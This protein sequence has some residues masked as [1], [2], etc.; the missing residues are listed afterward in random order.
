MVR[1][2]LQYTWVTMDL[3]VMTLYLITVFSTLKVQIMM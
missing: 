3:L 2:W 1:G